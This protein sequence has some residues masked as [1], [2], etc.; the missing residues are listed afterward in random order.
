MGFCSKLKIET[1][2]SAKNPKMLHFPNPNPLIAKSISKKKGMKM[3]LVL[4]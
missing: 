2:Y 4:I 3:K 1:I